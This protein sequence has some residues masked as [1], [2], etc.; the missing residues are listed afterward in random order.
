MIERHGKETAYTMM[1]DWKRMSAWMRYSLAGHYRQN[2]ECDK[3]QCSKDGGDDYQ[4][5]LPC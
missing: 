3:Q 2:N 4:S 5:Q 1:N